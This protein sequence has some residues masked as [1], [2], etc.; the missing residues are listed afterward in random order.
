MLLKPVRQMRFPHGV[1]LL[2][3]LA[4]EV[5]A[6]SQVNT[7]PRTNYSTEQV[8]KQ[9][10]DK[11]FVTDSTPIIKS[12]CIDDVQSAMQ[13]HGGK[14]SKKLVQLR[15]A[16]CIRTVEFTHV[17]CLS[18][19]R[20]NFVL[21]R[22]DQVAQEGKIEGYIPIALIVPGKSAALY[23]ACIPSASSVRSITPSAVSEGGVA[24]D[25]RAATGDSKPTKQEQ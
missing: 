9:D 18:A 14:R 10:P 7:D 12:N 6:F 15:Q 25:S 13:L 21:V 19:F 5:A 22:V 3:V 8:P 11:P 20:G 23:S 4:P 17:D 1:L 16:D 2:L 24:G